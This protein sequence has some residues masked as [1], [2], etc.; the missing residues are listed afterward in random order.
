MPSMQAGT[1]QSA[2][3]LNRIKGD[4]FCLFFGAGV[5]FSPILGH[6]N[7]RLSGFWT[8]RLTQVAPGLSGLE[9]NLHHWLHSFCGLWTSTEPCYQLPW[10]SSLQ[11]ACPGTSQPP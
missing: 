11:M 5:H 3:G 2:R 4:F 10:V 1:I 7:C 8:P 9:L 6:Q